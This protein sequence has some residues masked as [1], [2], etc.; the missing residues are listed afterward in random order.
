HPPHPA[1]V[2]REKQVG[3]GVVANNPVIDPSH[4][5]GISLL[6]VE[7]RLRWRPRLG[8]GNVAGGTVGHLHHLLSWH[9]NLINQIPLIVG[10]EVKDLGSAA[11]IAVA[12]VEQDAGGIVCLLPAVEGT[13]LH[14]GAA[15]LKPHRHKTVP[16]A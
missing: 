12:G 1:I 13:I 6:A 4:S 14:D 5:A 3:P 11:I 2:A 15:I 8:V 7:N 9:P 10:S 16:L